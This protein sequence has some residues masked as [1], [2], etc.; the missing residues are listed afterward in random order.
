L[1]TWCKR[2]S[3]ILPNDQQNKATLRKELRSTRRKF[4][5]AIG[6]SELNLV[7][8][9][10]A[11]PLR[12]LFTDARNIAI[13]SSVGD[14]APTH[15]LIQFLL[16]AGK[17]VAL[18]RIEPDGTMEFCRITNSSNLHSGFRGIS[19]PGVEAQ[20]VTPE[21]IIAPLLG[22]D[23]KLQRLGQ[24]G[25]YYDRAFV[26]YPEATRIGLAWSAQQTARVPIEPHDIPLHMVVTE[27]AIFT[28]EHPMP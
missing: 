5:Q 14:E 13:Y 8:R 1:R 7:F 17:T 4:V 12:L 9:V 25:G 27:K 28:R 23:A 10:P 11:G 6:L 16:D 3:R 15:H 2:E 26:R 24:G 21:I 19:E 22:F 20:Q 18:P